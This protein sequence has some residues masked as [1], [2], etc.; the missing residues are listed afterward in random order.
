MVGHQSGGYLASRMVCKGA[1]AEDILQRINHVMAISPISDLRP[2]IFT[3]RKDDLNLT[4]EIAENESLVDHE[5]SGNIPVTIWVGTD[6]REIYQEQAK[7]LASKWGCQW[8]KS[9][10][11]HH[12][13][14][15][16]GLETKS[17]QLMSVLMSSL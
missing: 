17:T 15:I 11:R 6:E 1:L 9:K 14:I 5:L 4:E 16:D 13:D 12:F 7:Q 10:N 8:F 2:L 3:R